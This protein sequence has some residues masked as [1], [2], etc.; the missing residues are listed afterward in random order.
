MWWARWYLPIPRPQADSQG[1][2]FLIYT[3]TCEHSQKG[4]KPSHIEAYRSASK[5]LC[6]NHF[7]LEFVIKTIGNHNLNKILR[8]HAPDMM[9]LRDCGCC[10]WNSLSL[11][12]AP[13]TSLAC[14]SSGNRLFCTLWVS[15]PHESAFLISS[16]ELLMLPVC[17]PHLEQG[18][19][20]ASI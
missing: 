19:G 12:C 16:Q 8:S 4:A 10:P 3:L 14:E 5:S 15:G 1:F 6:I 2:F 9:P 11:E 18:S 17:G 13:W 20:S 7:V